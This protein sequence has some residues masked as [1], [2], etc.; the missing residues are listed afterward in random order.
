M[1]Y[2]NV[3]KHCRVLALQLVRGLLQGLQVR[4]L[5]PTARASL[6]N[7]I[8]DASQTLVGCVECRM[9]TA[10]VTISC[11]HQSCCVVHLLGV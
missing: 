10:D 9:C 11:S 8:F 2:L 4:P 5:S 3:T 1:L 7:A 6:G